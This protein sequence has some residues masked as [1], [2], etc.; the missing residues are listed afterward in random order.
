MTVHVPLIRSNRRRSHSF[1]A[2]ILLLSLGSII[3]C[4]K[5]ISHVVNE[6][7]NVESIAQKIEEYASSVS[8]THSPTTSPVA[9]PPKSI[10][11]DTTQSPTGSTVSKSLTV[12]RE[13][14]VVGDDDSNEQSAIDCQLQMEEYLYPKIYQ[15]VMDKVPIAVNVKVINNQYHVVFNTGYIDTDVW[16]NAEYHCNGHNDN[17]TILSATKPG[18]GNLII[19][20]PESIHHNQS[21]LQSVS[22]VPKDGNETIYEMVKFVECE[23]LDV[24]HFSPPNTSIGMCT[25]ISGKGKIR[26]IAH[27]WAVY[28]KLL[29]VDHTWIYINSDWDDGKQPKR[30]YISWIPYN[31]NI[32]AYN[33]TDRPWTQRSEFFRVTAQVECVL[34]ARRMGVDWVIF[35]DIDEYVQINDNKTVASDGGVPVLKQLL[36][37]YYKNERDEIGGLVM[38][39]IPFG[40][41]LDVEK[42]LDKPFMID[43]VY[44]NKKNPK[45]VPWSRWKQIINPQNVHSYAIHWLGGGDVMKEIRFDAD[46]VR[47]NHYKEVK[48][49][50]GVF[51]TEKSEDLVEDT[52]LTNAYHDRLMDAMKMESEKS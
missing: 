3:F 31:L 47:I 20:C 6:Y 36:D 43:H 41:N 45:D 39:S 40:N 46:R 22:V 51:Q 15:W 49:G 23:Q 25:S 7:Q 9:P 48:K 35:T 38:N 2:P 37:M 10:H 32:K 44:R 13:V 24:K 21:M 14:P 50:V 12:P 29:G 17:A 26:E 30:P 16:Y 33:F 52:I 4:Y 8:N 34:R 42:D 18:R 27:E 11:V 1:L 19:Q 5:T 28:H